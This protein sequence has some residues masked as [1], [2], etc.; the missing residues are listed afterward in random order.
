MMAIG[1]PSDSL[2]TMPL[3]G[4]LSVSDTFEPDRPADGVAGT[5]SVVSVSEA[6]AGT[7]SVVPVVDAPVASASTDPDGPVDGVAGAASFVSVIDAP[8]AS[9]STEPAGTASFVSV[10]GAPCSSASTEPGCSTVFDTHKA[11]DEDPEGVAAVGGSLAKA[12]AGTMIAVVDAMAMDAIIAVVRNSCGM[13]ENLVTVCI[14]R[15]V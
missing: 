7:V 6:P 15:L 2:H 5:V 9:A 10:M 4:A 11:S 14:L 8:G 1:T 13:R 12:W 3:T